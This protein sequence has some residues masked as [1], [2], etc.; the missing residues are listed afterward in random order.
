MNNRCNHLSDAS[1][2]TLGWPKIKPSSEGFVFW[3]IVNFTQHMPKEKTVEAFEDVF[4]I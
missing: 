3:H 1:Y 2:R 4:S